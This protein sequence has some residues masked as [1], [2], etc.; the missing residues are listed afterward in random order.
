[1][2]QFG[3]QHT[4]VLSPST[5]S[6]HLKQTSVIQF[7]SI[8]L[9]ATSTPNDKVSLEDFEEKILLSLLRSLVGINKKQDNKRM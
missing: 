8:V 4:L 2:A 1:M 6:S 7:N 9:L 3:E 5:R